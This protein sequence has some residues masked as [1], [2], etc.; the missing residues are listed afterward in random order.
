MND[1]DLIY[2]FRLLL[3]RQILFLVFGFLNKK[4]ADCSFAMASGSDAARNVSHIVL[5]DDDFN[6]LPSVVAEG[7]RVINNVQQ[8]S[9]LFLV[10]TLFV[11]IN[12]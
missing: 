9:I 11:I 8:T 1:F 4:R 6:H 5:M 2:F 3:F 10:K 7:R 12:Y